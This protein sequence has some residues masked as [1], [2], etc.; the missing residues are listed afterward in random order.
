[1]RA[2]RIIC[3]EF[4]RIVEQFVV[5]YVISNIKPV[6]RQRGLLT[7]HIDGGSGSGSVVG[8]GSGGDH[9]DLAFVVVI[10]GGGGV[11]RAGKA[12]I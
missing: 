2:L 6:K 10:I 8:G 12:T 3:G 7:L 5:A 9:D 1:M 11:C 4:L